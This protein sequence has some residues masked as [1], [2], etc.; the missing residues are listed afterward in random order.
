M[1]YFLSMLTSL[2]TLI[3]VVSMAFSPPDSA[4]FRLFGDTETYYCLGVS[5]VLLVIGIITDGRKAW[6]KQ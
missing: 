5:V 2:F 6:S 1:L 4:I 3:M